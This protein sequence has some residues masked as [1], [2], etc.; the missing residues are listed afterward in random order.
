MKEIYKTPEQQKF[1]LSMLKDAKEILD[2]FNIQ[3]ILTGS[4]LLG[5]YRDGEIVPWCAG[6]VLNVVIDKK[7]IRFS[8]KIRKEFE[9][10]G[11]KVKYN[12]FKQG[13]KI[14]ADKK[15]LNVEICG[16]YLDDGHY[17]RIS[18][19]R[20]R[21]IPEKFF[22]KPFSK[23]TMTDLTVYDCPANIEEYLSH[24]YIDWRTPAHRKDRKNF[25]NKN[26][27]KKI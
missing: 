17:K 16:Y 27:V 14:R 7:I 8:K 2:S 23:I 15:G 13:W 21:I 1:H 6:A 20:M 9:K 12:N 11:Y 24:L 18:N 22:R 19:G 26:F 4:A 5:R 25:R 10:R 3:H